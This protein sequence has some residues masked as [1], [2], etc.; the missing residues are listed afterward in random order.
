MRIQDGFA[1]VD[2]VEDLA[3]RLARTSD[4][5][6]AIASL[7]AQAY[8]V[9]FD[10]QLQPDERREATEGVTVAAT[11]HGRT[12]TTLVLAAPVAA[13]PHLVRKM[14]AAAE[15]AF[16]EQVDVDGQVGQDGDVL[17]RVTWDPRRPITGDLLERVNSSTTTTAWP[18]PCLVPALVLRD[19]QHLAINWR[20]LGNVLVAAPTGAI[21]KLNPGPSNPV[22][23]TPEMIK[24]TLTAPE[25]VSN[26]PTS[27]T[28][29]PVPDKRCPDDTAAPAAR[30]PSAVPIGRC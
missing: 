3:R 25:P 9:V 16:G 27:R 30:F 23:E 13:R 8:A 1:E 20:T 22:C 6:S 19:R 12:S 11:R 24:Q 26:E 10:E 29:A 17:V 4:P 2:P 7:L 14:R 21:A 18:A 28:P 5:A 15:R